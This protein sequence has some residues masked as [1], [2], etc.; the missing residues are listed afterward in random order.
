MSTAAIAAAAAAAAA[1][2]SYAYVVG[3]GEGKT[4]FECVPDL[5]KIVDNLSLSIK[6]GSPGPDLVPERYCPRPPLVIR[7]CNYSN[8]FG[9]G[10]VLAN[11]T[12]GCINTRKNPSK[13]IMVPKCIEHYHKRY[14]PNYTE[15]DQLVL[16]TGGNIHFYER[17]EAGVLQVVIDSP[18]HYQVQANGKLSEASN[19][20]DIQKRNALILWSKFAEYMVHRLGNDPRVATTAAATG[21]R[22]GSSSSPNEN[23]SDPTLLIKLYQRLGN[24]GIWWWNNNTLQ[25]DFPDHTKL[26]LSSYFFF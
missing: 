5:Q 13:V 14:Q 19:E 10:F 4:V 23:L 11:G 2:T 16:K 21:D 8:K 15:K 6:D 1:E 22:S 3:P 12:I 20:P 7:W 26:L 9:I 24:V 25:L 18:K 17:S